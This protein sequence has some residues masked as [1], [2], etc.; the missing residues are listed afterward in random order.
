MK[1]NKTKKRNKNR[2]K[3]EANTEIIKQK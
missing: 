3:K 2:N 1:I